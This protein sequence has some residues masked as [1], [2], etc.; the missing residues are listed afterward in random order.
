MKVILN[1]DGIGLDDLCVNDKVRSIVDIDSNTLERNIIRHDKK[2]VKIV[3]EFT[4]SEIDEIGGHFKIV[5]VPDNCKYQIITKE[6]SYGLSEEIETYLEFT[7]D[8]LITGVG[9]RNKSLLGL[10]DKILVKG[11]KQYYP[12]NYINNKY[13]E[14]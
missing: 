13:Y 4:K 7:I 3:E 6:S 10:V 8:Q 2:L 14:E 12:I 11:S 1:L 9:E 5:L